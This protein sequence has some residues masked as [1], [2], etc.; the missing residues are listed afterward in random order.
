MNTPIDFDIEIDRSAT[1]SAK[2]DR[3][4]STD[5]LPMWVAD[6]D[7]MVAPAIADAMRQRL[8]NG[9]FGYTNKP[10]RLNELVVERTRRLYQ[11]N[12]EPQWL[13]WLPG[14]VSGL[15][16]GTRCVGSSGDSVLLPSVIY[17]P[18]KVV[19]EL[20]DRRAQNIP[21]TLSDNRWVLDLDW[22]E[23]NIDAHSRVILLCNPQNPGGS[24]YTR[25]EL[26]RLAE[27]AIAHDLIVC[28]DEVHCDLILEPGKMHIPI[29]MLDEQ[30]AKR[31]ITLMAPSKTF[32]TAGLSCAFAVIPDASLRRR[33]KKAGQGI[34]P[35]INLFGYT[36]AQA[37][38]EFGDDWNRQLLEYLK[39]SRDYLLHEI[40][41]IRGLRLD[42]VEATYLAWIDVSEL[43]LDD[44]KSFF[45]KAGV[46]LSPGREFGD[47][48]F[49]RMNFGCPRSRLKEA[50]TR[51]RVAVS[52]YWG[53]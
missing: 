31:S 23:A 47:D 33:F 5:I 51:M 20:S 52:D 25:A 15:H 49:V 27:L 44:P 12:I 41:T 26:S 11:W 10:D 14:V 34:V 16:M 36:S 43:G 24:V 6:T 50:V 42:T 17:A 30:I 3:Y 1:S 21:M 19:P 29:A 28:S 39:A 53:S 18:F 9:V 13:V 46:G 22:I 48:R 32:N 7:F 35:Y 45:E 2:W 8:L 40:N 38:Y 37:A 4:R